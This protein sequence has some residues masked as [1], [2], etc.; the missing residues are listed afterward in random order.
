[1]SVLSVLRNTSLFLKSQSSSPR[2]VIRHFRQNRRNAKIDKNSATGPLVESEVSLP[3]A[4]WSSLGNIHHYPESRV[5]D[6]NVVDSETSSVH[7]GVWCLKFD[8]VFNLAVREH[9]RRGAQS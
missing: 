2:H 4:P 6:L 1:M 8:S 5:F 9:E 7:C 3:P